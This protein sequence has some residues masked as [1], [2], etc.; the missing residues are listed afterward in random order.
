MPSDPRTSKILVYGQQCYYG[1]IV[2]NKSFESFWWTFKP[3]NS[4]SL[5]ILSSTVRLR[6]VIL[7]LLTSKRVSASAYERFRLGKVTTVVSVEKLRGPQI[8][9]RL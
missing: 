8:G 9:V 2:P 7:D 3:A 1:K 5:A 4:H 6:E